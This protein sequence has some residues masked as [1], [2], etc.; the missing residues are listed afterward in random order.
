MTIKENP[1]IQVKHLS[2]KYKIG[3]DRGYKTFSESVINLLKSP[4]KTIKNIRKHNG[5][6]WALKDINFE[7]NRGEILGI[8]G[9]NG[10]GKTTLL[11]ILTRIT[12][13][14]EGE[15]ILRGRVG[16]LLEV[17]T[18][19][20]PELTGREN[21][22]FNGA[23]LGMKKQEIE[24]K[25]DEIVEFSGVKKFLDTPLKRYSS[26]MQ[27]RL[28][29]SVAAHMDPEILLVDEVLAV[30]DTAFQKKCLG[31]MKDVAT[32]G[33]TV[34]F[35][36]HNMSAIRKLCPKGILLS[37]GQLIESGCMD[38]VIKKYL[39]HS[40]GSDGKKTLR[41]VSFSGTLV[42]DVHFEELQI[43]HPN[44]NKTC[45]SFDPNEKIGLAVKYKVTK[46]LNNFKV[47]FS[48]YCND[49]RLLSLHDVEK[50]ADVDPGWYISKI[51][52]SEN[53]LR[54]NTYWVAV[55]AYED[56]KT[57]SW[58]YAEDIVSFNI[59]E[60]WLNENLKDN[61]GIVNVKGQGQRK[62]LT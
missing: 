39:D 8:I 24:N 14:T 57:L 47:T 12:H 61:I 19:F 56:G 55:G 60:I 7:V 30:G 46:K 13:L 36:S 20:H 9:R 49:L 6:F 1:M 50:G 5:I 11:K 23:I 35:V 54:P 40:I 28:A 29:F 22:Y 2:K 33:R 4:L 32:G 27:V 15:V 52:L 53:I 21:I 25:F 34:L 48:L 3:M 58:I 37:N 44:S 41:D 18:G 59:E 43:Y 31:K 16:S 51:E 26:G 42:N 17:G 38:L 45:N 10:A 62:R